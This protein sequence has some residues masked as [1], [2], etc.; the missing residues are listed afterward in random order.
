MPSRSLEEVKTI[1]GSGLLCF[2][3]TDFDAQDV[4]D[5][6]AYGRRLSWLMGYSPAAMFVAGGAGEFFSLTREEHAAVISAA[7]ETIGGA[8]PV[9][10]SSG[11]GTH[12]AIAYAQ[13]AH[14]LGADGILLMPPYLTD[15]PQ[16]GLKAH[17]VAVCRATPLPVILYNRANCR[18]SAETLVQIAAECENFIGFK[19]G[20]G[21]IEEF[22]LVRATLGD[23]LV[24]LNGMPTAEIYARS[25]YAMGA[26]SY[27]SAI[28]NF[29]PRTAL[30]FYRATISGDSRTSDRLLKSF[31]LPYSR[32]RASGLGYAVSIV[33]AGADIVGKGA[34]S[35]RPPLAALAAAEYTNLAALINELG[36]QE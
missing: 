2:P 35:V 31:F 22:Q 30:E 13:A 15:A 18:L 23:R 26:A 11:H 9:I 17:I 7:V 20:V 27:T 24:C 19:D 5:S 16:Q 1:L 14:Q 8:V 6:T 12:A 3:L 32:I 28:F 21:D 10:A 36:P 25:Y 33:K 29:A 34:G 4:F